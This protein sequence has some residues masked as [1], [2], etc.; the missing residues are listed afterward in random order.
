LAVAASYAL[1]LLSMAAIGVWMKLSLIYLGGLFFAAILAVHHVVQIRGRDRMKCF[2][3]FRGNNLL[4]VCV[5]TGV[6]LDYAVRVRAW[7]QWF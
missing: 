6:A 4:G 1:F 3:A 7:P 5:F 2:A